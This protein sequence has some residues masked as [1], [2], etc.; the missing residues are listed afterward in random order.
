MPLI[1]NV[2]K[3]IIE[4]N[5]SAANADVTEKQG[6]PFDNKPRRNGKCLEEQDILN[7]RC[8]IFGSGLTVSSYINKNV[9]FH[10]ILSFQIDCAS[11]HIC[12]T[13]ANFSTFLLNSSSSIPDIII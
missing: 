5:L 12:C 13:S 6:R 2:S 11:A 3:E 10:C 7:I 1:Q 9:N 4:Q 8:I